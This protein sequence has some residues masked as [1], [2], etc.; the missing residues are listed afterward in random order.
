MV[1]DLLYERVETDAVPY[2]A[3]VDSVHS[4]ARF[5]KGAKYITVSEATPDRIFRVITST[6]TTADMT[7]IT[8]GRLAVFYPTGRR[9]K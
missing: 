4:F 1:S 3:F 2:H 8:P 9:K 5:R 6:P 7:V